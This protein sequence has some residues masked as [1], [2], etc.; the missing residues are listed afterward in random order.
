MKA[1]FLAALFLAAP[2]AYATAP[3]YLADRDVLSLVAS[4][5]LKD[6]THENLRM[7]LKR[8]LK[9]FDDGQF[10]PVRTILTA[11]HPLFQG[12]FKRP[13]MNASL[14]GALTVYVSGDGKEILIPQSDATARLFRRTH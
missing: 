13:H 14:A 8:Y 11:D 5:H 3:D 12:F 2:V 6:K 4:K 10:S 1:Q 7:E 9:D